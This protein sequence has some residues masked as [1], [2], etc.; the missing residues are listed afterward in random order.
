MV[1]AAQSRIAVIG[2]GIGGLAATLAL[3]QRGL[4]V[5]VYEQS[6]QLGEVGAGIQISSNGTRVL[7]ALGLE[8]PLRLVQVL[9]SR[10]QIRHWSTGE[11]WDW[12]ELGAVSTKRYGTPHVM[13]HRADLHACS[14]RRCI[15][16]S[17]TRFVL[18]GGASGSANPIGK[19]KY[20]SKPAKQLARRM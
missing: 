11:T 4:D 12:F 8:E 10:R 6:P 19:S 9:P 18:A 14:P 3:L 7:H 17:P 13:L 5:E 1:T 16:S 2:A 20:D 15:A